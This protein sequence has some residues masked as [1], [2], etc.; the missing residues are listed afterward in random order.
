MYDHSHKIDDLPSMMRRLVPYFCTEIDIHLL[1]FS[2]VHI[3][4]MRLFWTTAQKIEVSIA[5]MSR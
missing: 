3:R 5:V 4:S 2:H 1:I